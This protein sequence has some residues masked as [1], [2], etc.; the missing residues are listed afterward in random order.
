MMHN[1]HFMFW[2]ARGLGKSWLTALFCTVRC[3]L[4]PQTKICVASGTRTQANEVLSKIED[5]FMKNYE[6]GS[7]NLCREIT[8][9]VVSAN[10]AIIE[11]KNGSWI[12]VV[13]ASDTARGGRANLLILDEFRMIDKNTI[14][15]VLKRFMGPPRQPAYLDL[16]Q[17]KGKDE[18]LETNIEIYM[19]SCWFR[20]HWSFTKSK[21]YTYNLLGGR[22][23]YFVCALPYQISVKEGL[24]KR[25]EIED[26][27]SEA[28]FD[29]ALFDMEM[30]CIPFGST[31]KAFFTY[32]DISKRQRLQTA[33]YPPEVGR[34]RR[35]LKIPDVVLNE[36]RILSVDI[37]LMASG[38]HKNDACS[39]MINS[40][41][42][43]NNNEYIAN[44]VYLKNYEGL[45]S[46]ELIITIRKLYTQFKCTDLVIDTLGLGL[47]IY[48]GLIKDIVDP[49]TGEFYPALSCCNDK[50]MEERCKVENAPKV[51]WSIKANQS[52]NTEICTLLRSGFQNGKINLLIHN[53]NCEPVL[54]E[55]IKG[56]S[57]MSAPEQLEFRMPYIQTTLLLYE[58]IN[59]E[60]EVKG[61]NIKI[62]EKSGARKDRYSSL[63]YNY[64]VQCQLE[65]EM[66]QKKKHEFDFSDYAKQLRKINHRPRIYA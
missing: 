12:K 22:D 27:M 65:R 28:D 47:P 51:I 56:Y 6:W 14:T 17:Y 40:A 50:A 35:D 55:K 16:P 58:L 21:T 52:F 3:I 30:G 59:L 62:I 29:Q 4:F 1:T 49:N 41:I 57:S 32:E 33:L 38:K 44:I 46:D 5:D 66:L 25:I 26:E 23:N 34:N 19:S 37:A 42:P 53:E 8:K 45:V 48:D 63:A 31:D 43:T 39:I 61:T 2:A 15:T 54:K 18:L 10:N 20:S 11:F 60:Y 13:T 9:H 64:W 7:D 24:K 36:R